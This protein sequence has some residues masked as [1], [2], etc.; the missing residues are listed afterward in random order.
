MGR[1][2]ESD[3][4][5]K[6]QGFPTYRSLRVMKRGDPIMATKYQDMSPKRLAGTVSAVAP[7]AAIL[8]TTGINTATNALK[9]TLQSRVVNQNP[10]PTSAHNWRVNKHR[11]GPRYG[12]PIMVPFHMWGLRQRPKLINNS[13][14][15]GPASQNTAM[16]SAIRDRINASKAAYLRN[17]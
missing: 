8:G 9:P 6:L 14:G 16:A 11:Y 4:Q 5:G 17:R 13:S 2:H 1:R 7:N 10:Q 15:V 3:R 12:A